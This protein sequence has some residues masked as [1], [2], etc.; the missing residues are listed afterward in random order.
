MRVGIKEKKT[1]NQTRTFVKE[2]SVFKPWDEDTQKSMDEACTFD[3][4]MSKIHP[5]VVKDDKEV[6]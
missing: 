3:L 2:F 6:S 1:S 5:A 4:E